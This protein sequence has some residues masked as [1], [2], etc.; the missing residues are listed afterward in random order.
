MDEVNQIIARVPAWKEAK[1]IQVTR[2][3]GLT[4]AN[5]RVC[6]DG[7][8]F[9]LRI[10]GQNTARL[11]INREHEVAA[12]QN[13]AAAGLAPEIVAFIQP[14]GHL[15]T[16]WIAGRHW[17][18][19][20]FRTPE[21]VRLLTET[22]KRIHALPPNEAIFSPF[23]R[24]LSYL[25][26]AHSFA[27]PLPPGFDGYLHTMQ[28]VQADQQLDSSSWQHFCHNDLVSVNYL[29]KDAEHSLI[30]LDW[31][32]A[33][34]GDIYYDLATV[35]YTHDSEGPIPPELEDVMLAC[36]F[37]ETTAWQRRRLLGMKF[38]LMLF[39]GMWGLAQHGMQQAGLIPAVEGFDYR[40][41]AEYLFA[42][43]IQQLEAQYQQMTQ[44]E[45]L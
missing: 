30:V 14:E 10:S 7:E 16:R 21:N 44:P 27:V 15:V 12:L 6:V 3:A 45:S 40:D 36:Y 18:H 17:D 31:E 11:G 9:V 32:F 35:V 38:M 43:D 13:A 28:A 8:G 29:Y 24:V 25:E 26:T 23:Q 39:T 19:Q 42:Y 22:V 34:L 1:D 5:Y 41:F 20:E 37:G 33:G 4:N 2:I